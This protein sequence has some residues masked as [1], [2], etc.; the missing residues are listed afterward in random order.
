MKIV[1]YRDLNVWQNGK[2]LVLMAYRQTTLFPKEELYGLTSQ[3]RRSAVFI[4][5]NIAEGY[6]RFYKKEYRRFLY[7]AI[8]SCA[9]LETQLEIAYELNYMKENDYTNIL[10]RVDHESRMLNKLITK[11]NE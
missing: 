9:E 1:G 11:L 6:N 4:Q 3:I 8:G 5:S 2:K 10:E 7:I